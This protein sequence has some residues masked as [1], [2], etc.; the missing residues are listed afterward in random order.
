VERC[1][2]PAGSLRAEAQ[3]PRKAIPHK[4]IPTTFQVLLEKRLVTEVTAWGE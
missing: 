1:A 2:V 4:E 3:I